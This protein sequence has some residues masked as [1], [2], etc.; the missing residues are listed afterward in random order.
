[1]KLTA[2]ADERGE[3]LVE[4]LVSVAIMSIVLTA[5]L[6]ALSTGSLSVSVVHERVTAQ[7]LARAQLEYVKDYEPYNEVT[8]TTPGAY[9]TVTSVV[10]GY[11]ITVTASPIT[12][13]LQLITVTISHHGE[14][15]FTIENYKVKR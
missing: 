6:A 8:Q 1:V 2:F 11:V 15:V 10:P 12:T 14:R 13:N 5:F 3:S 9:P 4:I 7:N